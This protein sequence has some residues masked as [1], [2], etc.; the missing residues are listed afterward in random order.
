MQLKEATMSEQPQVEQ[1]QPEQPQP[2]QPQPET[3]QQYYEKYEKEEEKGE[4][5]YEKEEEKNWEEK[6][7]RDPL[8]AAIWAGILIW[9]GGI[10]LADNLDLVAGFT[11]FNTWGFIF[12]GGGIAILLGVV[13]RILL[14]TYRRPVG[15]HL[16]LGAVFLGIGLGM[17]LNTALVWP[18]VLIAIGLGILLRGFGFMR[19]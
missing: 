10:L 19:R 8:G 16:I 9:A 15:G 12:L 18:F 4:K 14:P 1:P 13:A 17:I 7:Q 11:W 6:W 5:E 2:E 3:A